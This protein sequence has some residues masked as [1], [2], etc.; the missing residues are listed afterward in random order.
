MHPDTQV[1]IQIQGLDLSIA[2]L[3]KEIAELPKH[4]AAIEKA[5]DSHIRKLEAD[6]AALAANQ[7]DRKKLEGEIQTH[8]QKISKLRD[9]MVGSKTNEQYRAFQNEIDFAQKEIR[10]AEDR[11]LDLMSEAESLTANVKRAEAALKEEVGVVEGEKNRARDRTAAD[12]KMLADGLRLRTEALAK[13]APATVTNYERIRKKWKGTVIAEVVSGRC[14]ACQIQLRP[15]FVQDLRKGDQ[16]MFCESCGRFLHINAPV[17]F[18][19]LAG[20]RPST[21]AG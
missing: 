1:V 19:D 16:Q 11:I 6:K 4:I 18:D 20:P 10:K 9:Q 14:A 15:Q 7:R 5:L 3:E 8:E 13:V 17:S 12:Q 2:G 21:V